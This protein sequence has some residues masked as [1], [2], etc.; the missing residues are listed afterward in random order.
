[1]IG[2]GQ[3][4]TAVGPA[5]VARPACGACA[6]FSASPEAVEAGV[7]GLVVMGSGYSS[8]RAGDGLCRHLDRYLSAAHHCRAFSAAR[9]TREP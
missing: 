6:H 7:P 1:M 8:V 9:R 2:I 5:P 4:A 3:S